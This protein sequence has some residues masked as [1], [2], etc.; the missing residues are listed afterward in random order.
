MTKRYSTPEKLVNRLFAKDSM[1]SDEQLEIKMRDFSK[2]TMSYFLLLSAS[3]IIATLGLLMNASAIV[4]GSMIISPLTWP[5]FGLAD[6]AALGNRKRIKANLFI[7]VGSIAFGIL[8]A[9][10][11]TV[12]SPLKVVNEE[13]LARSRPTL[14][15]AVVALTAGAIGILA[16]IRK[17]ISDTVA[18]VAIALSLAPPLC[19]VGISLALG[20]MEIVRGSF[21]LLVTNALSITLVAGLILVMVHYSWRRKLH[22]APRAF[23]VMLVSLLITAIPLYQL[24]SVYSLESSSYGV[25]QTELDDYFTDLSNNASVQNIRTNLDSVGG[26]DVLIIDADVFLPSTV[27]LTYE[28]RD[29]LVKSLAAKLNRQVDLRLRIQNVALLST[30]EDIEKQDTRR[31]IRD[32]FGISLRR[33]NQSFRITDADISEQNNLWTI[34]AQIS[35]PPGTAPN[36][37]D[38]QS[39]QST[40]EEELSVELELSLSFV[41]ITE[42]RSER[43]T[44]QD[45]LRPELQQILQSVLPSAEIDDFTITIFDAFDRLELEVSIPAGQIIEEEVAQLLKQTATERL[46]KDVQLIIKTTVYEEAAY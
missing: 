7:L 10:I 14:L 2:I 28:D 13:I 22:M 29:E 39:L 35:G 37:N 45:N 34:T 12:F 15:D 43:Q 36:E 38:I 40:L 30:T 46:Q 24:L 21:L 27:A 26:E 5:M 25:V 23:L 8:L 44:L 18:G 6:G 19:V 31:A 17:N 3:V 16:I 4:I 42:I 9:Y 1:V 41:V 33:L 32:A 11:L 20:E